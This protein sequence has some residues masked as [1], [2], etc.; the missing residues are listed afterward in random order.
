MQV[1]GLVITSLPG[2]QTDARVG[3]KEFVGRRLI[4]RFDR[5]LQRRQGRLRV[6]IVRQRYS[7][8]KPP[9]R[10]AGRDTVPV[11]QGGDISHEASG[12]LQHWAEQLPATLPIGLVRNG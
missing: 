7:C 2:A 3:T 6:A 8:L 4:E 5:P 1:R 11:E 9:K 10:D 12:W